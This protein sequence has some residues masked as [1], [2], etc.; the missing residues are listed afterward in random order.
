MVWDDEFDVV[1]C[2]Y[3][4]GSLACAIV[5]ADADLDVL[6]AQP[7]VEIREKSDDPLLG[8]GIRDPETRKYFDAL[9][10]DVGSSQLV[11]ADLTVRPVAG[12]A[13]AKPGTPV[14]PFYGARLRDWTAQCLQ[15]PYGVLYTRLIGRGTTAMKTHSGEEIEVKIVGSLASDPGSGVGSTLD[16]WLIAQSRDRDIPTYENSVLQRIVFEEDEIVGVVIATPDGPR[17][18][19]AR[20][21]IAVATVNQQIVAT[22]GAPPVVDPGQAIQVALVG[23]NASRFA[24]VEL[25]A[26]DAAA[27]PSRTGPFRPGLRRFPGTTGILIAPRSLDR[28][29]PAGCRWSQGSFHAR[30]GVATTCGVSLIGK[31]SAA[32]IRLARAV[33]HHTS[34]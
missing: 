20:H 15:S 7:G 34:V 11:H 5:A 27:G 24:R 13:P 26:T 33:A 29:R 6:I 31:C 2:G 22:G 23:H 18:V 17:A 1:C 21:G 19:R 3:G 32:A 25:L 30:T 9:S 4:F 12:L 16:E 8:S 14:E 10:D 28:K